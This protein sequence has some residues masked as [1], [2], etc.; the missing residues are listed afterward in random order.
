MDAR[1]RLAADVLDEKPDIV[2]I[3]LGANDWWRDERPYRA[4]ADDL[5]DF[6]QRIRRIGAQSR[7]C[8]GYSGRTATSMARLV[9]KRVWE[10]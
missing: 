4:W 2:L 3:E 8:W 1:T 10:R 6:I 5:E 9:E 7:S